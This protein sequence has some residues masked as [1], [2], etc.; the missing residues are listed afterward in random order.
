MIGTLIGTGVGI[1]SNLV[2]QQQQK[3]MMQEQQAKQLEQQ[4]MY[5]SYNGAM[6]HTQRTGQMPQMNM[7]APLQGNQTQFMQNIL[8]QVGGLVGAQSTES[9]F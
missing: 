2:Q 7:T 8:G 4:Q 3:A 5:N 6:Q 1:I 9:L